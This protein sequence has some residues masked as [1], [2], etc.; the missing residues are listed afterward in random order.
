LDDRAQVSLE[1]AL[2]IGVAILVILSVFN[3]WWARMSFARDVGEAGEAK[4]VGVLLAESI[5]NAYANGVNFSITL[6]EEEI[7]YTQ[8]SEGVKMEGGGMV[9]P[10]VIDL[11][12]NRINITKDMSKTGGN[13]WNT[14]VSIIPQN[15]ER[16][17]PTT[18]YPETTIFYNGTVVIIYANAANIKVVS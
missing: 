10:I 18:Q 2:I 4:M 14:T 13:T 15:I 8:L 7:N 12:E 5:N 16:Q 9:L 1:A 3:I 6:T 11:A 17:D